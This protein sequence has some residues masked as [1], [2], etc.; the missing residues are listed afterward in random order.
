MT[1]NDRIGRLCVALVLGL[2][3][4]AT[5]GSVLSGIERW[6]KFDWDY[7]YFLGYS[8]NRSVF[9]FHELPL[10]NPWYMG[11]VPSVGNF[12]SGFPNPWSVLTLAFGPVVAIKLMI[13]FH[14]AIGLG[15]MYWMARGFKMSRPASVYAAGIFFFSSWLALRIH[16]GHLTYLSSAYLPLVVG[17]FNRARTRPLLIRGISAGAVVALMIF[18][19]GIYDVIFVG[20]VLGPLTLFWSLQDRSA[21]PLLTALIVAG[22]ALGFSAVKLIPVIDYMRENPRA[23]EL[24]TLLWLR[25][26]EAQG[27]PVPAGSS[28]TVELVMFVLR[29][30]LGREYVSHRIYFL[31]Y[32]IQG[33]GW[34]EYGAFI[35]LVALLLAIASPLLAFRRSWPWLMVGGLCFLLCAGNIHP[36]APWTLIHHLPIFKSMHCPSRFMIPCVFAVSIAA[37]LALDSLRARFATSRPVRDEILFGLV[38]VLALVDSVTVFRQVVKDAFPQDPPALQAASPD[39]ITIHGDSKAMTVAV[40]ANRCTAEGYE[41]ILPT[42]HVKNMDAEDY[43]GEAYF[44]PDRT[45]V[46]ISNVKIVHW[47]PNTVTVLANA[48]TAGS[49]VLNRNAY[50][51]WKADPPY[52]ATRLQGL[53][54][55]HVEPGEHIVRFRFVPKDFWIG[56]AISLTTLGLA[57]TLLVRRG[58]DQVRGR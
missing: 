53:I 27:K 34:H 58:R 46:P 49:I 26:P 30:F 39:L 6:G 22:W 32:P 42:V 47:S 31:S 1:G 55:S 16:A 2:G 14:Q 50:N 10:W 44:Q 36:L 29:I 24:G 20:F 11:G 57:S 18:E 3:M 54:A 33:H 37:A 35:G 25:G 52:Q 48:S 41:A 23:T 12:Q 17:L 28:F 7:F 51:G 43:H 19:G 15:S 38:V 13:V 56:T 40:L 5:S 21:R 8:L 45:D 9:E 4:V